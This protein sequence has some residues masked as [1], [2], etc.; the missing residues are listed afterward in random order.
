MTQNF[1]LLI[2]IAIPV[3]TL[4][5][6]FVEWVNESG[7]VDKGNRPKL[8]FSPMRFILFILSIITIILWFAVLNKIAN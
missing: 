1:S 8:K 7:E 2:Y 3:F 5:Y 4:L 6:L